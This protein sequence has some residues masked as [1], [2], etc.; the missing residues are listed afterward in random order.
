MVKPMIVSAPATPTQTLMS[1]YLNRRTSQSSM[2][3]QKNITKTMSP[4]VSTA[5]SPVKSFSQRNA[6]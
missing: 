1:A 5:V 3:G 2:N 4:C 6:T